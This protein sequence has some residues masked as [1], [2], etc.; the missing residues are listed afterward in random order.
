MMLQSIQ[1][2]CEQQISWTF[3]LFLWMDRLSF[4]YFDLLTL[5]IVSY[6]QVTP[7][8]WL[9]L[10]AN[11]RLCC[12]HFSYQWCN[13]SRQLMQISQTDY[14]PRIYHCIESTFG[15]WTD[16]KHVILM[17]FHVGHMI[18]L[19]KSQNYKKQYHHQSSPKKINKKKSRKMICQYGT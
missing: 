2:F 1:T 18:W 16:L 13:V 6:I 4:Y 7:S 8:V 10:C 11:S 3:P 19:F 17:P 5:Y 9:C 15:C 14:L 12:M